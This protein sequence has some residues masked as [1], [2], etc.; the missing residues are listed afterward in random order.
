MPTTKPIVLSENYTDEKSWDEWLVWDN[1]AKLKFLNIRLTGW[2][3]T[4]YQSLTDGKKDAFEHMI[5]A[6]Q[7]NFE[8]SSK[9]D[10]YVPRPGC[11]S[12]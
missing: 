8:S 11:G 7:G 5:G 12:Y 9:Q 2:V 4:G 3:Q 6:L 1:A 10:L